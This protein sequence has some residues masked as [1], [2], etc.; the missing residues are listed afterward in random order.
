MKNNFLKKNIIIAFVTI[1]LIIVVLNIKVITA[2]SFK[3]S[4]EKPDGLGYEFTVNI[5]DVEYPFPVVDN[6]VN[7]TGADVNGESINKYDPNFNPVIK[8][9]NGFESIWILGDSEWADGGANGDG[10]QDFSNVKILNPEIWKQNI[11]YVTKVTQNRTDEEALAAYLDDRRPKHY[12][13]I[14]GL[15]ILGDYYKEGAK[16]TTTL[17]HTLETFDVNEII[18]Y[19]EEDEGTG[20]GVADS[21]LGD[22]VTFMEMMRGPEGTTSPSKYFYCSPRPW[23][24]N[25]LGEVIEI[26]KETIGDK[27]FELYDSNVEVV[28]A[29]LYARDNRG[30]QKDGG[31]P[32]GHTNAAYISAFAYAYAVPERYSEMLTRASELGE[33]RVVAGMHSPLDVIGG[34]VMATAVSASF[35]NDE[36]NSDYK[37]G[38]Y[39]NVQSYFED[40]VPDNMSLYEFAQSGIEND[41]W[42][43]DKKNKELYLKRMTYGFEK[44]KSKSGK[45]MIVPKGAEVLLETRLPYLTDKQRRVVLYTTGI[46]SGYPILDSTNGWGRLNL[47]EAADGYGS[48]IGDVCVNMNAKDGGF[49]VYDSW[50]NNIDGNGMLVKDGTGTLELTGKNSYKGGTI[51]C[52]GTLIGSS[53]SSFGKGDLYVENGRVLIDCKEEFRINGNYKQIDGVFEVNVDRKSGNKIKIKNNVKINGG[54]LKI[55]INNSSIKSGNTLKILKAN[56]LKGKFDEI[57]V[58]GYDVEVKYTDKALKIRIK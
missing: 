1:T 50:D 47:V 51:L 3:Q 14:D 19:S 8:L 57:I 27:T 31:Y 29:L 34:R 15:G 49:N 16:A 44:D 2:G 30:I 37:K 10:P 39:N 32:S 28:P 21:K 41:R 58:D 54:T 17:N 55:N 40:I 9:L 6:Y 45:E 26:G 42:A 22:F 35:L 7:Q 4:I 48:F 25:D 12:S 38:A 18:E 43:S 52:G 13:I 20:P 53:G 11:S 56:S 5:P 33:N 36:S 23:R 24:M 46:D